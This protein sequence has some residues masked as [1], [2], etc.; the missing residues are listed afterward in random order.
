MENYKCLQCSKNL[1]NPLNMKY[2][3]K[4][5]SGIKLFSCPKCEQYF[6]SEFSYNRH[7]LSCGKIICDICKLPFINSKAF[8]YH[9]S[10]SHAK[11]E[12]LN[13]NIYCCRLCDFKYYL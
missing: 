3:M 5:C 8:E 10:Q 12:S 9:K 4:I 6:E 7:I 1:F 11:T 13:V 2:H